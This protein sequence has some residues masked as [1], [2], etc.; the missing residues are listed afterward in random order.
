[1]SMNYRLNA[2][3]L[4][5]MVHQ[6]CCHFNFDYVIFLMK[7]TQKYRI[8]PNQTYMDHLE[9]LNKRA[10]KIRRDL[11]S[12][13]RKIIFCSFYIFTSSISV[14][15]YAEEEE[16]CTRIHLQASRFPREFVDIY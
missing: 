11:V 7:L 8:S 2:E 13:V 10:V 15:N 9:E 6:A 14:Y 1:M 12:A 3:I 16:T 5:A 4:G